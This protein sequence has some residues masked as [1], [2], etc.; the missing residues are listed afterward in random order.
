MDVK[1]R[2]RT[3][4]TGTESLQEV[5]STAL[6]GNKRALDVG[7]PLGQAL[8]ALIQTELELVNTNLELIALGIVVSP[9]SG[10]FTNR[11][12]T[13]TAVSAQL[14]AANSSR[15]YFYLQNVSDGNIWFNF[16]VAAVTTQP[17][18]RLRPG[19]TFTLDGS[20]ISTQAINVIS[21]VGSRDYVAKEG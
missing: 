15:K 14:A 16:G 4:T 18:L 3:A 10:S 12:G 17:S 1:L 8:L 2:S 6:A 9:S 19:E 5:T 21:E 13:A 7:D 20:F 11:S